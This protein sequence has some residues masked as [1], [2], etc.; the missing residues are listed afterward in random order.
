[1]SEENLE[2]LTPP[3]GGRPGEPPPTTEEKQVFINENEWLD[4]QRKLAELEGYKKGVE[5]VELR[6]GQ[7]HPEVQA[8]QYQA[9][10]PPQKPEFQYHSE[11][12]L[13]TAID[14]GDLK[15][16]HKMSQHNQKT[17]LSEM[18]WNLKTNE[19]A[20]LR[21]TGSQALSDLSGRLASQQMP[22]LDIP[23]VKKT[24]ETRMK[25]LKAS[26]QVITAEVHQNLYEWAV[27]T[28]IGKVQEKIQQGM[29][30]EQ[31]ESQVNTPTTTTGR[32]A[33]GKSTEIPSPEKF[34]DSD[35]LQKLT[36]KYQGLSPIQACDREFQRHGGY[37]EWYKKFYGKEE[38][39]T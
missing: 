13:Q 26:D 28:N 2:S 4:T 35:A 23:E 30:R 33:G 5:D 39:K 16:Y 8:S 17:Q 11:E 32:E 36:Q 25:Q 29:L 3:P 31:A 24:Y 10:P 15:S 20:P 37:A 38:E 1:M 27:G 21:M 34:F 9:P 19:I 6:L 18:E 14:A 12:E 22:H 7:Q